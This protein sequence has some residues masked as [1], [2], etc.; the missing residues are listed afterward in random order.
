MIIPVPVANWT[1][2]KK[3]KKIAEFYTS[4]NEH[5]E[6]MLKPLSTLS[7]EGEQDEK[8]NALKVKLAVNISFGA[9]ICLAILQ[10]YAA[11]SSGSLALFAT[12]VDAGEYCSVQFVWGVS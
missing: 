10:L 3:N 1:S 4:Q 11:I 7:A 2:R 6:D 12:S 8:D 5:I 9:N